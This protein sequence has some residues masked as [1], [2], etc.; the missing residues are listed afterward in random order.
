MNAILWDMNGGVFDLDINSL[1]E[2]RD[3]LHIGVEWDP[4][5]IKIQEIAE[6]IDLPDRYRSLDTLLI[7]RG[8]QIL[9]RSGEEKPNKLNVVS[10]LS[11]GISHEGN[12]IITSEKLL[13][14]L[15]R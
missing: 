6:V 7:K 12:A 13:K 4:E 10:F 3:K 9:V 15:R 1:D 2:I 11:L 14:H 8:S 5:E